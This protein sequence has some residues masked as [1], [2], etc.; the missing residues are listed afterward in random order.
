VDDFLLGRFVH[1]QQRH[2]APESIATFLA[3][4]RLDL[5]EKVADVPVL[6]HQQRHDIGV[7][8]P[9]VAGLRSVKIG[10]LRS[11]HFSRMAGSVCS[12]SDSMRC[13]RPNISSC[14]A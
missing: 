13:S 12:P 14:Y 11:P 3:G 1:G 8:L 10:R 6:S 5:V 7:P 9:V 2:Q 4:A